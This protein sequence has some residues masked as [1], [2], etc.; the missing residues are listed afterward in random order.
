MWNNNRR[1][2]TNQHRCTSKRLCQH[3]LLFIPYL[4]QALK[5]KRDVITEEHTYSITTTTTEEIVSHQ[6][7]D[8]A[9]SIPTDIYQIIVQQYADDISWAAIN[10][11]HKIEDKKKKTPKQLKK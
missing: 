11:K 4:A 6:L 5:R 9:Y 8:H 7:T 1:S 3:T 2:N 10:A